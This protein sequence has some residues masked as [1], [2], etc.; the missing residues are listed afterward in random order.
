LLG[1]FAGLTV[2]LGKISGVL[3]K[4][5]N[6]T[7]AMDALSELLQP[8]ATAFE[9]SLL[10]LLLSLIVL[11]WTQI[12][13][14]RSCL[15]RCESLLSSWLETVLPLQLGERVMAPLRDSLQRL[16]TTTGELPLHLAVAIE[17]G[18]NNAFNAKLDQLFDS[19]TNLAVEAHSAVRT[20]S[21]FASTLNESGQDFV[22]AAQ[23]FQQSDF[24]TTLEGSV[25]GLLESRELLTASTDALSSRLLEVRDN[26]LKTQADWGLLAKAAEHE[27]EASRVAREELQVGI[28]ALHNA[29]FMLEQTMTAASES[30][31]QLR[32]ARLEVMRDRKLAIETSTA[33]QQRLAFDNDSSTSFQAF[34]RS[35]ES[36]ITNWN[37]NV[38]HLNTLSIGFIEAVRNAKLE[39]DNNLRDRSQMA[40]QTI[41]NL[42]KQL[43]DELGQAIA[44]QRSALVSLAPTAHSAQTSAEMLLTQLDQL[45][46]RVD[47]INL[48]T[49]SSNQEDRSS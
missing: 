24:A 42:H 28:K 48:A 11:I 20:L 16:N 17:A 12:N 49:Y 45:K 18:M 8:M 37:S 14:T 40:S 29:T 4:N 32:E 1:T 6:P 46:N 25:H 15:E 39:D 19:Q 21:V 7:Q 5:V 33:I 22:D 43:L 47:V 27:L 44:D 38:E 30:A 26:L 10:G 13:G 23:V 41:A 35:L 9:T 3:A 2:G 34:A 36:M 31:K